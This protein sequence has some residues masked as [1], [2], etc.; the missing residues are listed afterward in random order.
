MAKG[1]LIVIEGT[2]GSG[3]ATQSNLLYQNLL[4]EYDRVCKVEYPNYASE[5]AGPVKMYLRGDFGPHAEDVNPYA[6][7][8]LFAVDRFASYVSGWKDFYQSGGIV[9]ADRYTTANMVHQA[10]KSGSIEESDQF[11][12]WLID[13]EF[14][15]LE[16]PEPDLVFF[17]DVPPQMSGTLLAKRQKFN[18]E[19]AD[20]HEADHNH[21]LAAYN[22]AYRVAKKYGWQV[23]KCTKGAEM[24]T[25]NDIQEE[26]KNI[27]LE[28]LSKT[29]K[30]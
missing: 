18:D 6:A 4:Q 17:L 22:S 28:L 19:A 5:S 13:L 27:T 7:S 16:L 15:K 23:I 1:I 14:G 11:L 10:A 25:I 8:T 30:E 24:R 2:D 20:I 12:T 9:I 21:I 3:K 29:I 26:L